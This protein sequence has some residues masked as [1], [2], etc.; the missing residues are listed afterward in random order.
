MRHFGQLPNVDWSDPSIRFIDL[1]GDGFADVMM[2]GDR[3]YTWY[4][5]LRERGFDHGR[6]TRFSNEG[7]SRPRLSSRR[8]RTARRRRPSPASARTI[9]R[10]S[11]RLG[12][13]FQPDH[14]LQAHF[15]R[16]REASCGR[17]RGAAGVAAQ[18]GAGNGSHCTRPRTRSKYVPAGNSTSRTPS[19][20]FASALR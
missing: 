14:K 16:R 11:A 12:G 9:T 2:S 18:L 6:A 13:R 8:A 15:T 7:R 10:S 4:P 1:D 5:S 19:R 17:R 3:V 20:S